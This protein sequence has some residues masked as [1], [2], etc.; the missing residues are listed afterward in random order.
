MK[1]SIQLIRFIVG[2]GCCLAPA[3]HARGELQ[4]LGGFEGAFREPDGNKDQ[5]WLGIGYMWEH[6][7]FDL[8]QPYG[9]VL[10]GDDYGDYLATA[11]LAFVFQPFKEVED[12][13]VGI[14]SGPAYTDV[15]R[16][17]S[18]SKWNWTTDVWVRYKVFQ[19]GY[20]HTSNGGLDSPNSGLDLITLG[21]VLPFEF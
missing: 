17:H 13:R 11:G 5:A 10:F 20:S 12:V 6:R 3:L 21:I 19:V 9:K 2:L 15:G 16:P 18:G 14:Q 4:L 1:T 8:F 7:F